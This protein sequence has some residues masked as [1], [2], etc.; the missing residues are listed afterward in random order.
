MALE[1]EVLSAKKKAATFFPTPSNVAEKINPELVCQQCGYLAT[2]L[3]L[4]RI[5][6]NFLNE[7]H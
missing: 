3:K 7:C 5:N 4:F 6:A 1:K 2:K